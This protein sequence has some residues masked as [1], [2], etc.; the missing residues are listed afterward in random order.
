MLSRFIAGGL[1]VPSVLWAQALSPSAQV[2]PQTLAPETSPSY[3]LPY[4]PSKPVVIDMLRRCADALPL[5]REVREHLAHPTPQ[6]AQ[7]AVRSQVEAMVKHYYAMALM[8]AERQRQL[9]TVQD[10]GFE[11][12][13]QGDM[14]K[15]LALAYGIWI[16]QDG[17]PPG[18]DLFAAASNPAPAVLA[19]VKQLI[20]WYHHLA[21]GG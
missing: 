3:E 2:V 6:G 8:E 20:A 16:P 14:L 19:Q 15:A 12:Q 9:A 1:L 10:E 18:Y 17:L 11:P 7:D 4:E 5:T 21:C 13:S